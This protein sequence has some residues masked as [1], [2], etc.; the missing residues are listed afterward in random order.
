[1]VDAFIFI[2]HGILLLYVFFSRK[3]EPMGE[4]FLAMAFVGI[5][6]SVGWVIT[7]MVT[8]VIFRIQWFHEWYWHLTDTKPILHQLQ[9]REFRQ[10]TLSLLLLTFCEVFF[11]YFFFFSENQ[12]PHT[13]EE[14]PKSAA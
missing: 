14:P 3:N 4:R 2:L 11:Y 8:D 6:F 10:D 5:V 9:V 1:M 7:N 13:P 12:K